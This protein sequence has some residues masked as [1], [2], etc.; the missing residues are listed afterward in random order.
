MN[1]EINCK[2]RNLKGLNNVEPNMALKIHLLLK[3][4]CAEFRNDTFQS[5]PRAHEAFNQKVFKSSTC[6]RKSCNVF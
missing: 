2:V 4:F 3:A 6:C 1:Y 5:I